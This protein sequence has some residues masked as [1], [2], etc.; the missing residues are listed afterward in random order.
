MA[1]RIAETALAATA[2]LLGSVVGI[3]FV[4]ILISPFV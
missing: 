4:L 2:L 3:P 1:E